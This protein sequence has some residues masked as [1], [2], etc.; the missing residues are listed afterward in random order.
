MISEDLSGTYFENEQLK[1]LDSVASFGESR[2][3]FEKILETMNHVSSGARRA[4]LAVVKT[5]FTQNIVLS[6]QRGTEIPECL[7]DLLILNAR[8]NC[9][10]LDT[11][12]PEL[13]LLEQQI[14]DLFYYLVPRAVGNDRER[15]LQIPTIIRKDE[16]TSTERTQEPKKRGL[17]R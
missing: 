4:Y 12:R 14:T 1:F 5:I 16:V 3:E 8:M 7:L 17:F 11:T 2:E 6:N 9:T 15:K 13:Y 10:R